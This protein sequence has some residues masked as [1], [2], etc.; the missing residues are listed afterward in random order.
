MKPQKELTVR[1]SGKINLYLNVSK[2]LRSDGYHEIK[3]IMQ[4][5][6]LSD[7]LTFRVSGNG[8][9]MGTANPNGIYI[10]SNDINIPLDEKNNVHKAAA[11]ILD[12]YKLRGRYKLEINIKKHIPVC[13]GLAGGSTNAAATLVALNEIFNLNIRYPVLLR[14]ASL[15]G[16]DVPFC[17][18]GG[19]V[20]AEG[21]GERLIQLP[22]LPFYWLVLATDGKKLHTKDIYE[23]FDLVGHQIKPV[24]RE[25]LRNIKK[26]QYDIFFK[27]LENDLEKVV[28]IEDKKVQFL[29][30]KSIELG[31]VAA[32]MTG[33]GPTVFALCKD[34]VSARSVLKQL[35][36]YAEKV[37]LTHTAPN[38]L[39]IQ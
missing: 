11:V 29:K 31:A 17:I 32:Q 19:T 24:H 33:S 2:K 10:T 26:K 3:S 36:Y 5:I 20:L 15:V 25:L 38:S 4:S 14:M 37:I 1:A 6:G 23:M 18:K 7:E 8:S 12:E 28:A 27:N 35:Q 9:E 34:L 30:D 39:S 13:A 21:R 22:D 16:S